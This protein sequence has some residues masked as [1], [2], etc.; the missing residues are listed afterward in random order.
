MDKGSDNC[1]RHARHA[2]PRANSQAPAAYPDA[3]GRAVLKPR[4]AAE[5]AQVAVD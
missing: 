4:P 3:A 2:N 5:W 1:S